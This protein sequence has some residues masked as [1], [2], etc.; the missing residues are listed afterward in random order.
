MQRFL[1]VARMQPSSAAEVA[2]LFGESDATD[3]PRI[4]GTVTRSLLRFHDLY[5]HYSEVEDSAEKT[6]Q[7]IRRSEEFTRL[8]ARLTEHITPYDPQ[9]WR[10]PADAMA[11]EFYRWEAGRGIVSG[12]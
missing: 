3:L 6:I 5:F 4:A 9:T 10:S 12:E 8:N 2:R 7:D 11:Q 1:I